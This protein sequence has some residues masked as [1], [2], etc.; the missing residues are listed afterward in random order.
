MEEG[1]D[2]VAQMDQAEKAAEEVARPLIAFWGKLK[3]AG[4]HEA[5]V[6]ELTKQYATRILQ[7]KNKG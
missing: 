4:M 3:D 1:P 7:G 2:L 5:I 6:N